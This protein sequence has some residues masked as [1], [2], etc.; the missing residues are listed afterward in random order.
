MFGRI[1]NPE[2]PLWQGSPGIG[3]LVV[4]NIPLPVAPPPLVPAGA[5]MTALFDTLWRLHDGHGGGTTALFLR[6]FRA[7]LRQAT[8]LWL[9]A[10]PLVLG[11]AASWLLLP[12]S[13]LLLAKALVSIVVAL[14]LPFPWFLQ[15]RF[16]NPVRATLRNA[17]LIPLVR[18]PYSLAALGIA[19]G[20]AALVVAVVNTLPAVLPPLLLGGWPMVAYATMPILNRA[21]SPWLPPSAPA[22]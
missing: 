21:V 17:L 19:A 14:V 9:I 8:A 12:F 15:A 22:A 16:A 5:A 1:F 7:N 18:L 13:E 2:A 6:S 3:H 11:L 4:P 20:F 10:A